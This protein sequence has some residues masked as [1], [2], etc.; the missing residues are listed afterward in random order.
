MQ[1]NGML[2]LFVISGI[3]MVIT[4]IVRQKQ[5]K[6]EAA[7]RKEEARRYRNEAKPLQTPCEISVTLEVDPKLLAERKPRFYF[8]L[9]GSSKT[10]AE[11]GKTIVL[12]TS[13]DKNILS[14]YILIPNLVAESKTYLT[15]DSP[16]KVDAVEG[17]QI[18]IISKPDIYS[19]DGYTANLK[20]NF[21]QRENSIK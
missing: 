9:N 3:L 2:V 14:G 7:E 17:G 15:E 4:M 8:S 19:E 13:L 16:F 10:E 1:P 12:P 20:S 21:S 5:R 11:N 6:K 18:N